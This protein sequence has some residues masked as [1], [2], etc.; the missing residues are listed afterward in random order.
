MT[1]R[2]NVIALGLAA[3]AAPILSPPQRASAALS[4]HAQQ[5]FP[6]YVHLP[7]DQASDAD[8]AY[9][10]WYVVG[11]VRTGRRWF[12]YKVT[13][14]RS[15]AGP[16]VHAAITDETAGKHHGFVGRYEPDRASFSTD[17]LD[18]RTPD[19]TLAGPMQAMRLSANLPNAHIEMTLRHTG[20]ALYPGGTG[21]IPFA[22]GFSYYYSLPSLST[23]GTLTIDGHTH[24]VR[25]TSWLDRQWGTW[26]WQN[27]QRW[28]WMAVH[29]DNGDR[30][31]VW[32][33]IQ[34]GD[35]Q[36]YATIVDPNGHHTVASIVPLAEH[37]RDFWTSP[38]T[39]QTYPTRWLVEIPRRNTRLDIR[40]LVTEQELD[41]PYPGQPRGLYEAACAVTGTYAGR[42]TTGRAYVELYGDWKARPRTPKPKRQ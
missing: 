39:G 4:P 38:V 27:I 20:P 24:R 1:S 11:H 36:A 7:A 19:A 30:L 29:L 14:N 42:R 6:R 3:T 25:G 26:H 41:V 5:T 18:L 2:R 34:D 9:E 28:T 22:D 8:V 10:W 17:E 21:L 33:L 35:D 32:N 16:E 15:S 40:S 37:A 31:N 13:I 12:G 23:R